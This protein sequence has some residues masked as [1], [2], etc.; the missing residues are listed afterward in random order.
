MA[1]TSFPAPDGLI[2]A[3]HQCPRREIPASGYMQAAVLVALIRQDGDYELLLTRR[4]EEVETHKG[5]VAF[6][7][8]MRDHTDDTIVDTAL[9]EAAEELGIPPG[10]VRIAGL[11]DDL[12]T[13]TGFVVTPVVG[14][15]ERIPTLAPNAAEVA[16]VFRAPLSFFADERNGRSERRNVAGKEY[17][18]WFYDSG[19]HLV[20][21]VTAG[22]IRI[23]LKTISG[24]SRPGQTPGA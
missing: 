10:S 17:D 24:F 11:L 7:G 1:K 22:I 12:L 3:I 8:G 2:L 5:Q 18:V 15:L 6:P 9:R 13:P 23:L 14:I 19:G 20:W 21:G 4:T 16:D